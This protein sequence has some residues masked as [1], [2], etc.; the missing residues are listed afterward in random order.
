MKYRFE[1]LVPVVLLGYI[2]FFP[3]ING[4]L[5]QHFI[6]PNILV[7]FILAF[8]ALIILSFGLEQLCAL[9][10]SLAL[11]F[12]ND[13]MT[14]KLKRLTIDGAITYAYVSATLWVMYILVMS[15]VL[16]FNTSL[17]VSQIALAY[18][19]AFILAELLLRPLKRRI[20]TFVFS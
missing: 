4:E 8:V 10:K 5:A 14:V 16:A 20:E 3:A 11:F 18:T 2:A 17:L 1:I 6:K 13:G 19:Y 9:V 12:V 7:P 15:G